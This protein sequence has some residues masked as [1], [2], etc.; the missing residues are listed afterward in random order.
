M[1]R[2]WLPV[3]VS[4][5]LVGTTA[6]PALAGKDLPFKAHAER[7]WAGPLGPNPSC[8]EGY[9][10]EDSESIGTGTHLGRFHIFETL[11]LDFRTPPIA[12]FE[13]YGELV[14]ANGDHLTFHVEGDFNLISGAMTS[15]GWTFTGG[16]GRFESAEGQAEDTV[17]RDSEGTLIGVKVVGT[18][19]FN[20]S[21]RSG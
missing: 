6:V 14:T 7:V 1:R 13:V 21:D 2:I 20:A 5:L 16:T 3:L 11:C 10:G 15:S 17:I 8:P 12:P 4:I 19:T 9:V 18:I